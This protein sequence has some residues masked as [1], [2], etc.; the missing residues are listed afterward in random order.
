[1]TPL[2]QFIQAAHRSLDGEVYEL[3]SR[4]VETALEA[5]AHRGV[6]VRIA[7]EEHPEGA[8]RSI[9][10]GA[11]KTLAAGGVHVEW[12]SSAF[13]Y[14]HAKYLVRD[15]QA[16][17]IGS[18][19]WT[20][21]A[22]KSNREF[23][24]VDTDSAVVSEAEAVFTADWAHQTYTGSAADL[25]LSP[26]NSRSKITALITGAHSTLD[27]YA[28]ELNDSAQE[29]ALIAA[30][31]RGVRVRLVCTGDG[32]VAKLHAGGVQVV[33]DK[34]LYIHAKAVVM[35]GSVVFIG[36]ENISA[37]S[38]DKNREM[39]LILTDRAVIATVEQAF[40]TDF[41]GAPSPVSPPPAAPVATPTQ[42]TT[43]SH[44][45]ALTVTASVSPNPMP[46]N[47]DATLMAT[48]SPGASCTATVRYSS[49]S[50][51]SSFHGTAQVV[52][53]SG[54]ISWSWHESTKGSGGTATVTCML[55]GKTASATVAFTVT[56]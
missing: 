13:T 52:P 7:L 47:A 24:V 28:E 1:V 39:G 20:L 33:I 12:T 37:T 45:G 4:Q 19:N 25:V 27:V 34:K 54:S 51:P 49:G 56:H 18:P 14:T 15:D 35:D 10:V 36:S 26:T 32:D 23:A 40:A 9:P 29:D 17:W 38:L 16:A 42:T 21:S 46:Y 6:L 3:T 55:G 5:A 8:S 30:V 53:A 22:F 31:R 41:G 2:A 43:S 48:T 44:A 50:V 11:Y